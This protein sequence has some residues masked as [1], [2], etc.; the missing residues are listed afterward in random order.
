MYTNIFILGW[1]FCYRIQMKI[2]PFEK[3]SR[4]KWKCPNLQYVFGSILIPFSS[5]SFLDSS[6]LPFVLSAFLR[7]FSF[8]A[9]TSILSKY[10]IALTTRA[11]F[12]DCSVE[13]NFRKPNCRLK[14]IYKKKKIND[15]KFHWFLLKIKNRK[16]VMYIFISYWYVFAW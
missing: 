15:Y 5:S 4:S 8:W 9:W 1:M 3:S 10:L 13:F 16:R 6:K 7:C 2:L 11:F 12:F 14:F